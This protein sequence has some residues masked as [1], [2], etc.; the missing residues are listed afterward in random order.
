MMQDQESYKVSIFGEQY[1]VR[2]DESPELIAQAATFV[3]ST[4]KE[5]ACASKFDTKSIAVLTALRIAHKMIVADQMQVQN[6]A[7]INFIDQELMKLG[8]NIQGE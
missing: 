8:F 1:T 4:M 7:L 3:D 5:I 2:T 6:E